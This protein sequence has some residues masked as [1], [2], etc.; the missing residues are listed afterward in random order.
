MTA[1]RADT[2]LPV[3]ACRQQI[4]AA[5]DQHRTLIIQG[6]TGSG[7]TT[8]IPR[9][10]LEHRRA[11]GAPVHRSRVAVT[12]PRRVAAMS[13]A[14]R[15]ALEMGAE[16][17]G[18]VGYSVRFDDRS[19]PATAIKFVTDGMLLREVLGDPVLSRYD[20]II[21]DEA[22]ERTLR[23]DILFGLLRRLQQTRRPTLKLVVMSAT[24][25]AHKL[26]AFFPGS[27]LLTVPGRQFPVRMHYTAEPQQDYLDA[28]VLAI[29]Q[30]HASKPP[31]DLLVF[32]TGQ[33]EIEAVQRILLEHGGGCPPGTPRMLVCPLYAALPPHQ[34]LAVFAVTPAGCRKIVLATNVA[35]TSITIPGIR[36][37]V[38]P[39]FAKSRQYSA[40]TG[41]ESLTVLPVSKAASRQRAGRAGREAPG[42]CFRLYREEAFRALDDD[43]VPEILR[44]SLASVILL[45][46]AAGVADVLAFEYLDAPAP[47]ALARGLEELLALGALAR[48]TGALTDAGRLMAECPLLPQH[49]RVLLEAARLGCVEEVLTVLAMLSADAIFV[50]SSE[51]LDRATAAKRSF[52]HPSGDH[53]TLLAVYN[54]HAAAVTPQA[55]AHWCRDNLI[56]A[57]AMRTAGAVRAQLADFCRAHGL[58]TAGCAQDPAL[59]LQ[60]FAAG[61]FMQAAFR[62]PDGTFRTVVG[63]QAVHIHPSSVLHGTRPDCVIYHELTLTS[64]CYL[65]SV[66]QAEPAWLA[67]Y[68]RGRA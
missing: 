36:Y 26:L 63:R 50:S 62:L 53:M 41:M 12:Q 59:V 66:S 15:V 23:T 27:R 67:Q 43:T 34:Q 58:P 55:A 45:M 5:Y 19:G 32:L 14:A 18:E 33:D 30:L 35:E 4:L 16:L 7:K 40:R 9:F 39:G 11:Q 37:V 51:E 29:F 31:G 68:A 21:L 52:R 49:A 1:A 57:R 56:D 25:D 17:G 10:L 3:H 8:Q 38:D 28:A 47:E 64:K 24:L 20:T 42:E 61:H 22:H 48:A 13:L 54:A 2:G 46:K 65:R 44:T 6:E 60:A